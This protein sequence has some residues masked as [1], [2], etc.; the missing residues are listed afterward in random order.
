MGVFKR[1]T[2]RLRVVVVA[3]LLTLG[4]AV[5][6]AYGALDATD[7]ATG[8]GAL[9]SENGGNL[10]TADGYLT[11]NQNT[12][13]AKNTATGG[14]ALYANT[15]GADNTAASYLALN[16]N[17]TGP[18]NTA[19]GGGAMYANTTGTGNTADG[20]SALNQNTTGNSNTAIGLGALRANATGFGNTADGTEAGAA[21]H[22]N[23]TGDY[24][25]FVRYHAA[26]GTDA[27]IHDAT[28]I[29][30]NAVVSQSDSIVLGT[31]GVNVGI[32]TPTPHSLLQI[33]SGATDAFGEYVQVPIVT[34]TA[35]KPPDAQC[36]NT[37][38]VGR[39]VLQ[40]SGEKLSLWV[41]SPR[42]VWVKL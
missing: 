15:T 3:A 19:I 12:T 4:L 41:C 30:A 28:A 2:W 38:L 14:G 7:T 13:G 40:A 9:A 39:L 17:T 5:T 22:P 10:N 34:S 6:A 29:G 23:T 1:S 27:S 37:N 35:K 26:P 11:L 25:T 32:K 42:G 33:G 20:H 36:D 31:D 24:N 21:D 18:N 8:T 16:Q